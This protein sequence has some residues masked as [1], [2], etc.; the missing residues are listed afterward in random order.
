MCQGLRNG[1]GCI[2]T[3]P[4]LEAARGEAIHPSPIPRPTRVLLACRKDEKKWFH[5]GMSYRKKRRNNTFRKGKVKYY[6]TMWLEQYKMKSRMRIYIDRPYQTPHTMHHVDLELFNG[7]FWLYGT[8][9]SL[10]IW[11]WM[12]SLPIFNLKSRQ[13]NFCKMSIAQA[14]RKL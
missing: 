9:L 8:Y 2:A 11:L 6:R 7:N 13:N 5:P 4:P 10:Y 12:R 3:P 14:F 1:E